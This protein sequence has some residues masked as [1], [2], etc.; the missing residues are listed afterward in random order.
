ML[1]PRVSFVVK[2][3]CMGWLPSEVPV[4]NGEPKYS[5]LKGK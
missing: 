4:E 5:V 1:F 3:F 2:N